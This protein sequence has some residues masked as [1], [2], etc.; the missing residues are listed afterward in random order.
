M[1]KSIK[2]IYTLI[3]IMI[4]FLLSNPFG[5]NAKSNITSPITLDVTNNFIANCKI[6]G[7]TDDYP[8]LKLIMDYVNST[9]I[10]TI[11]IFPYTGSS[12]ILS[13]TI[14]IARSN[15]T[16]NLNCDITFTKCTYDKNNSMNVIEVG[17]SKYSRSSISN[18][19]I[20]GNNIE[21]NGNG[22]NVSFVET[23][24]TKPS[25]GD[26]IHFRRV[27]NGYISGIICNNAV[28]NGMRIYMC[29][30]VS[31]ENCE[32]K[33]TKLDNGLTVMGLPVYEENWTYNDDTCNNNIVIRNCTAHNNMDVGFSASLCRNVLFDT[34]YSYENGSANGFNAGGGFSHE[35]LGFSTY[36]G[37][38]NIWNGLTTFYNCSAYNNQNYGFYTDANGT[39]IDNCTIDTVIQ[40]STATYGRNLRGGNGIFAM[41]AKGTF[42]IIDSII[43]N[44]KSYAIAFST[45]SA[46]IPSTLSIKN[47]TIANT[48]KGIY[49]YNTDNIIIDTATLKNI[50]V[51][52]L[53]FLDGKAKKR[54]C[55][56][57]FYTNNIGEILIG[58]A[59][60]MV[61]DNSI[62]Y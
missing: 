17:F 33:N 25:F 41:G 16:L 2:L 24:H 53:Y 11:L 39:V 31:V 27:I 58:N 6:D 29:Q 1:K 19:Q 37:E 7:K 45:G 30:N 35:C 26:I 54:I 61:I 59:K 20:I 51:S 18:I 55:L 44:T 4:M 34:C 47:I 62:K 3:I 8:A 56:R 60:Y 36:Y 12:M 21:I 32:F 28:E 22:S 5:V 40:N 48:A 43:T 52:P 23:T 50:P 14:F 49:C 57:N 13:D 38:P 9:S 46:S 15:V 42:T 10:P